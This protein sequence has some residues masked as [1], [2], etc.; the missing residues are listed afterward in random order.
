VISR[1]TI[2]HWADPVVALGEVFRV[3]EPGGVALIHDIRR[4]ADPAMVARFDGMRGEAGVGPSL[5][6]DKYTPD[7]VGRMCDEAGIAAWASIAAPDAG[8][9]SLGFELRVAKERVPR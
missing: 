1:S 8:P 3:L 9:A 4:D 2:H 7:E 5:L 6:A